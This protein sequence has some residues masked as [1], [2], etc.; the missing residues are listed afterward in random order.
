MYVI[1][2]ATMG[3]ALCSS[4]IIILKYK[5]EDDRWCSRQYHYHVVQYYYTL[6]YYLIIIIIMR[7]IVDYCLLII[8]IVL[9]HAALLPDL[10]KNF[11]AHHKHTHYLSGTKTNRRF[12]LNLLVVSA[13]DRRYRRRHK[14]RWIRRVP[15][16][17][18]H[19]WHSNS[20]HRKMVLKCTEKPRRHE[21][22]F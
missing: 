6:L 8:I 7:I 21:R 11:K 9:H 20:L 15:W 14:W 12:S 13:V 22:T 16:G 18:H 5:Y 1:K 3:I 10:P 17:H 19:A 2:G 4:R